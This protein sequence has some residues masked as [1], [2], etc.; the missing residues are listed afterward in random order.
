LPSPD[1]IHDQSARSVDESGGTEKSKLA[2]VDGDPQRSDTADPSY[3]IVH[4]PFGLIVIV[5]IGNEN[6]VTDFA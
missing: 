4:V 3:D 1:S 5:A 2:H 6:G